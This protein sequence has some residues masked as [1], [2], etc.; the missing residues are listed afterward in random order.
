MGY[1]KT[2]LGRDTSSFHNNLFVDFGGAAGCIFSP[3]DGHLAVG[4][5]TELGRLLWGEGAVC[6]YLIIFAH[7]SNGEKL[8]EGEENDG[9]DEEA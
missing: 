3:D 6:V 5:N 8:V 7:A 1:C 4:N 9:G 2:S